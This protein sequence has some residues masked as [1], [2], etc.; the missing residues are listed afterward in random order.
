MNIK[1]RMIQAGTAWCRETFSRGGFAR[2]NAL[3]LALAV[4][5]IAAIAVFVAGCETSEESMNAA[6]AESSANS[7]AQTRDYSTNLLQEGDIVAITFRYSTNFNTIQK[8]SLDGTLNLDVAGEV[9]ASDKTV[10]QLQDELTKL[11][12]SEATNDP[13]TVKVMTAE[14]AVYV[15]GAVTRPGKIPLEHPMT[16][17][18]A[19]MEAS[20]SDPLEANLSNVLVLRV[21]NGQQRTYHVNVQRVLDG[22]DT[23]V[24]Y[25]K[26]FDI[27]RV[28]IKVFNY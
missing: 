10:L 25:L 7:R 19:I 13:I 9:K 8:I 26:P 15:T 17:L 4:M 6:M 27:V 5:A 12:Q 21:E 11:Y 23:T 2:P 1:N 16:V 18:E 14:A 28:P 20:G 3:G 22:K 24:F